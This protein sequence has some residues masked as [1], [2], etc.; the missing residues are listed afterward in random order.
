MATLRIPGKKLT[1]IENEAIVFK[2]PLMEKLKAQAE[3]FQIEGTQRALNEANLTS[4]KE[5]DLIYYTFEDGSGMFL[6]Y[7]EIEA[8]YKNE[9]L[10]NPNRSK[11]FGSDILLPIQYS[12][13]ITRNGANSYNIIKG[14]S[15]IK[16]EIANK[17]IGEIGKGAVSKI[18][19]KL[20]TKLVEK[21]GVYVVNPDNTFSNI[22]SHKIDNNP[23][24]LLIHG[25]NSNTS[26]AF[27]DKTAL[28]N[29][30]V[31]LSIMQ[32]VHEKYKNHVLAFEHHTLTKSIFDNVLTLVN[33]LPDKIQ[34]TIM[35]HSRGG[36]I[37]DGLLLC[38]E[39]SKKVSLKNEVIEYLNDENRQCDAEKI[40]EIL[41]ILSKKDIKVNQVIKVACPGGGTTLLSDNSVNLIRVI[42]EMT[43]W[44]SGHI[45]DEAIELLEQLVIT[46]IKSKDNP[47]VLPGLEVMTPDSVFLHLINT[48]PIEE[49]HKTF[50]LAGKS[51]LSWNIF[52]SIKYVL[53]R[54]VI[55]DVS[56][57]VVNTDS[58]T[59]GIPLNEYKYFLA[60]GSKVYHSSYFYQK[61]TLNL[62]I[63]AINNAELLVKENGV[64]T[65]LR[66]KNQ[67]GVIGLEYGSYLHQ[68][69]SGKKPITVVIPG[70]MA[71][72]LANGDDVWWIDYGDFVSRRLL[73][74]KMEINLTAKGLVATAYEKF[75]KFLITNGHDVYTLPY[76]WR[77]SYDN[78]M[79]DTKAHFEN[80]LKSSNNQPIRVVTHS[81]GGLLFRQFCA[82]HHDL[83]LKLSNINGFRW[84][85]LGTPWYG[86]YA[87]VK[88]LI[89]Q[90]KTLKNLRMIS[91]FVSYKK[92]LEVFSKYPG[93]IELLPMNINTGI[94]QYDFTNPTVWR[95]LRNID[96]AGNYKWVLP[97]DTDLKNFNELIDLTR[98]IEF[99]EDFDNTSSS[100]QLKESQ[101]FYIAGNYEE[102]PY[103]LIEGDDELYCDNVKNGDGT[104]TWLEGI[105]TGIHD[106]NKFY[107][108]TKHER[109]LDDGSTFENILKL[110]NTGQ[111]N[112]SKN[113]LSGKTRS[114]TQNKINPVYPSRYVNSNQFEE[115]LN[116]IFDKGFEKK[117]NVHEL[118]NV[119][120][121]HGDLKFATGPLMVGHFNG[122]FIANAERALDISLN[123][124]LTQRFKTKVYPGGVGTSLFILRE[125]YKKPKGALVVGLG[126]QFVLTGFTL[127]N[128][129]KDG[130]LNAYYQYKENTYETKSTFP[131]IWSTLLIGTAFGNLSIQ[132]SIKSI[133]TGVQMANKLLLENDNCNEIYGNVIKKVEFIEI[134]HDKAY[135]VYN[136]LCQFDKDGLLHFENQTIDKKLGAM[137]NLSIDYG[138]D[139]W[140]QLTIR[141]HK[142]CPL[143]LSECRQ[144]T[145]SLTFD[146]NVGIAKEESKEIYINKDLIDKMLFDLIKENEGIKYW[147]KEIS[148]SLFE[149]L[150]PQDFKTNIRMQNNLVLNL[151][152]VSATYPWELIQDTSVND[153]PICVTAGLIR[154][155]NTP[156]CGSA[157]RYAEGNTILVIGDPLLD[158]QLYNQLP[159]AK[160]EARNVVTMFEEQSFNIDDAISQYDFQIFQKLY[161]KSHRLIHVAA[162]GDFDP[163]NSF[164]SG[165]VI[166]SKKIKAN[167]NQN[168]IIKEELV[169]LTA[170]DI[171]QLDPMPEFVFINTCYSGKG[172]KE[173]PEFL[174]RT[175]EFA[176]N[177]GEQFIREGVKAIIVAGWPVYDD[178]AMLFAETFYNSMFNGESFG[179]A[180]QN[181]REACF[182]QDP[183]K[184]TWGAYQCYGDPMYKFDI[185]PKTREPK[186]TIDIE[187]LCE[188]ENI[189]SQA[190]LSRER[191]KY[192]I[193]RLVT[194]DKAIKER[195]IQDAAILEKLA[196]AHYKLGNNQNAKNIFCDLFTAEKATFTLKN[197]EQIYNVQAKIAVESNDI[198]SLVDVS[199]KINLLL[200]IGNTSERYS[201]LGSTLKRLAYLQLKNGL[202]KEAVESLKKAFD[203]YINTNN[204]KLDLA[205]N[206][207]KA[208][209]LKSIKSDFNCYTTHIIW[210]IEYLLNQTNKSS[211][212][213]S[214]YKKGLEKTLQNLNYY[215]QISGFN[216]A[217]TEVLVM[218][219]KNINFEKCTRNLGNL[220]DKVWNDY[221]AFN[222]LKG[223]YEHLENIIAF[224]EGQVNKCT[225]L[226]NVIDHIRDIENSHKTE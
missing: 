211:F 33:D 9:N 42:S 72:T 166:G 106:N 203:A 76:D 173:E 81:K 132:T 148:K 41:K 30:G 226:Q 105:P 62:V 161:S 117:A 202:K 209:L 165:I 60:K 185:T 51:S 198:T 201:L 1:Q 149:R 63:K 23:Y 146:L 170:F 224:L 36:L 175:Y 66:K 164:K 3:I 217:I 87:A 205:V 141:G 37:I 189:T 196:L 178:L 43:K 40:L 69:I 220:F 44:S 107:V 195:K 142:K 85:M 171:I 213:L 110:I 222:H 168:E 38:L 147:D 47:E 79:N 18:A 52:H 194:V 155:L 101:I 61:E 27:N 20:E 71:S 32:C 11:N 204:P 74:M 221:G 97:A 131:D 75:C 92:L 162:H 176:A 124:A 128:T 151:D 119:S 129:I 208:K 83:Y 139:R 138:L 50:I 58:M 199:N 143:N 223:E 46:L 86:S 167:S 53:S 113:P 115:N 193:N 210:Q 130:I 212:K 159:S 184:N 68:V 216:L 169:F 214:N 200:T 88:T 179:Q 108:D 78:Q 158:S 28:E 111:C 120:I 15:I 48:F 102:T 39:L 144:N 31:E 180:V 181:A 91:L 103:N 188:L 4:I 12:S 156:T 197:L 89:G 118:I 65:I 5:D 14:A 16:G 135:Y 8:L 17:I 187:I 104:V 55:Q 183:D 150:I 137:N 190:E 172:T 6:S 174:Y 123:N 134:F 10:A 152:K 122:E 57:M 22:K 84:I 136:E 26:N 145:S 99:V 160:I 56:D 182:D 154:Q 140:N 95:H 21:E 29:E 192:L 218:D 100:I 96:K 25:T 94:L 126:S 112:L 34:L 215:D 54:L 13:G 90:S 163:N 157:K 67:R 24:L 125:D 219:D 127:S 64:E 2:S 206:E 114:V 98:V 121:T 153:K 177:I 70:M 49:A 186:L 116:Q 82:T 207:N 225:V 45:Y 77:Q 93:V 7:Y 35:S 59:Q 191:G 19:N 109:L 133:I 80:I 73:D